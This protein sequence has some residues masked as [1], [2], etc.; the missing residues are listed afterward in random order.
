MISEL[1]LTV[2]YAETDQMGIVHHSNYAIWFEAGRMD[3]LESLGV[4]NTLIEEKGILIPLYELKCQFKSPA[5]FGDEVIVRSKV[6]AVSRA[7]LSFSY[8]VL[9]I[10]NDEVVA[11]GETCHA[12]TDRALKP[13]NAEK[14]IPEIYRRLFYQNKLNQEKEI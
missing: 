7:R 8:E 6:Q 2:R 4:S 10:L 11:L 3:L 12:W 5:R 14:R 9:K 1:K 13:V